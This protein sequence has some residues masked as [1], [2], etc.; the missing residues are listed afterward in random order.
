MNGHVRAIS[1]DREILAIET[2][3]HGYTVVRLQTAADVQV[4]D[5]LAWHSEL[6]TGEQVYDNLSTRSPLTVSVVGHLLHRASAQQLLR[7]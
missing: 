7:P 6:A 1:A 3:L 2:E 5:E 4:G